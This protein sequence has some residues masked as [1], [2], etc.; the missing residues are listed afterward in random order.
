ML[1]VAVSVAA[2]VVMNPQASAGTGSPPDQAAQ[3]FF[4]E[5]NNGT[6]V[7]LTNTM[8]YGSSGNGGPLPGVIGTVDK[9]DGNTITVKN[10]MDGSTTTV[11]TDAATVVHKQADVKLSDITSGTALTA[12]G[13]KKDGVLAADVI[14]VGNPDG[15]AGGDP[16]MDGPVQIQVR[17]GSDNPGTLVQPDQIEGRWT[18]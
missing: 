17:P 11:Q 2:Y 14:Q 6:P 9:V 4:T 13:T 7:V 8:S 3:Q 15:P 10:P 16:L 18:R 1:L 5:R 12:I